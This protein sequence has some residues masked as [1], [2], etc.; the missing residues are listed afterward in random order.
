MFETIFLAVVAAAPAIVAIIGIITAVCKLMKSF[1][2]LKGE[3]VNVKE[4]TDL[5]KELKEAHRENREL[6]K[7]LNEVLTAL[8]R[9]EHK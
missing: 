3:V 7:Q 9:V 4:Y 2:E 8:T 5:K 1:N 6:K